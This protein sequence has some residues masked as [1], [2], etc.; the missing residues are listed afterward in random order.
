MDQRLATVIRPS[1]HRDREQIPIPSAPQDRRQQC[2]GKIG[3][4][5][6]GALQPCAAQ[7]GDSKHYSRQVRVAQVRLTKIATVQLGKADLRLVEDSAG[8]SLSTVQPPAER[9]CWEIRLA[10][11]WK[12]HVGAGTSADGQHRRQHSPSQLQTRHWFVGQALGPCD[13]GRLASVLASL[14]RSRLELFRCIA[15][16]P[17]RMKPCVALITPLLRTDSSCGVGA[18]HNLPATAATLRVRGLHMPR[19]SRI[20]PAFDQ[21]H[22]DSQRSLPEGAVAGAEASMPLDCNWSPSAP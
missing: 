22:C 5:K 4:G 2:A 17:P 8:G 20:R 16:E 3:V 18:S 9:P 13:S 10:D 12:A 14:S 6:I 11:H 21:L 1:G 15:I 7:I 19:S